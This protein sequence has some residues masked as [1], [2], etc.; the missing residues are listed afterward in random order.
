MFSRILVAT[1]RTGSGEAAV[2]FAA[3]LAREHNGP[4]PVACNELLVGGRGFA[5]ESEPEAMDVVDRAVARLAAL[6][7][8]PTVSTSWSTASPSPTGS[9]RRHRTG[10]PT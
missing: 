6:P 4:V 1:D 5:A 8:M 2:S 10:E 7:S 9:P 3:A